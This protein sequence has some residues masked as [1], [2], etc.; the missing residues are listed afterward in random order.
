MRM[1]QAMIREKEK[2][3]ILTIVILLGISCFLT[4]Y[5]HI[6]LKT[7]VI[8]T[9]FF[10]IPIILACIWWRRKGLLV[11]IL[12]AAILI[13][14]QIIF[15]D[16]VVNINDYIRAFMFM[17]IAF[18]VAALSEKISKGHEETERQ[19]NFSENIITT[20]PQ[21]LLILDKD[22]RI[23]KAN[24]TFY[25]LFQ[26]RPEKAIGSNLCDLLPDKEGK[27][28]NELTRIVG[29]ENILEGFEILYQSK[30]LGER[31]LNIIAKGMTIEEEEEEV[32][33][34]QDIT[35]RKQMEEKLRRFNEE[36]ELEVEE[37][38][39]DLL[40]EKNYTRH[41]IESSTDFQLTIDDD[42]KIM[43]VNRAFEEFVGKSRG[44]VIGTS[45][46]DYLPR[47]DIESFIKEIFEKKKVRNIELSIEVPGKE[48]LYYNLSGTLFTTLDG[49]LGVYIS[50]RDM[51]EVRR[52]HDELLAKEK[53]LAHTSR[54]STLGEM[55]SAMA[56]EI[57]Q[58]LS[59]ISMV[60][61]GIF[62][63]IEKDRIDISLLPKDLE[64]ILFSINRID[65]IIT[66][67][68]TFARQPG[69]WKL[70]EPEQILNNAFIILS[71]QFRVHSII[72]SRH[73]EKNLPPIKTDPNQLEQVFINIL[74]NA[75]QVLNEKKSQKEQLGESFQKQMVVNI[76]QEG[77]DVVFEFADNGYGVPDEI[78]S[79]IFEPFFTTKDPGEG[80]GLGLSIAYS[81]LNQSLDGRIWVEDNKMRG[82]SFKVALPIEKENQK[83]KNKKEDRK[84]R[85]AI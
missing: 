12:L 72:V 24:L 23:K 36:L 35:E 10:Y 46:Y 17:V 58:P 19:K 42:G 9:H 82:A 44:D 13:F 30:K 37:R 22:L 21:S 69:E 74:I 77:E 8:F 60:A 39:K 67:M 54:L 48:I 78:K 61:E 16:G 81:I 32:I 66:H 53:Q 63:D 62:R 75:D 14:S 28:K 49:E 29:T 43:D 80:T 3:K 31:V 45:I 25:Q 4:Y 83:Y 40:K 76:F 55:A 59:I 84:N 5:F 41:L 68:R 85:G 51:T 52:Q 38:T 64:D 50:A 57:N 34:I 33:L 26:T 20:V 73:I 2:I 56:H 6:V 15:K 65:R 79:R 18:V 70:I 1:V 71:E 11:A 27:L 47:K 7:A